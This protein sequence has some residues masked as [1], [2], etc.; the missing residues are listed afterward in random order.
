MIYKQRKIIYKDFKDKYNKRKRKP[1][2]QMK[3]IDEA[4]NDILEEKKT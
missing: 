4:R 3:K 1:Q 2:V